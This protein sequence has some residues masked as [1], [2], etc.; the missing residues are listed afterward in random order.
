MIGGYQIED[1]MVLHEEGC[2]QNKSGKWLQC[3]VKSYLDPL[4]WVRLCHTITFLD[5]G[6]AAKT[7]QGIQKLAFDICEVPANN[8]LPSM[9]FFSIQSKDYTSSVMY[10]SK[11]LEFG[12]KMHSFAL[13]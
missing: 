13:E 4:S 8:D 1:L 7:Q 3:D 5:N 9:F 6:T 2:A 11:L 10:E 12:K